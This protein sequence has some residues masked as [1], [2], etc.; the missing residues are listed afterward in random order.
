MPERGADAS[1]RNYSS[2]FGTKGRTG[3]FEKFEYERSYKDE[4]KAARLVDA[5]CA[6]AHP[7]PHRVTA[8]GSVE[9]STAQLIAQ[10]WAD[11]ISDLG[12][13]LVTEADIKGSA[14]T[15][16]PCA[17][18]EA[19]LEAEADI[20]DSEPTYAQRRRVEWEGRVTPKTTVFS[21][22]TPPLVPVLPACL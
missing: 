3:L 7:L 17:E 11:Q 14:N 21:V 20:K 22:R 16:Q 18:L 9:R 5:T 10:P 8:P 6:G 19:E 13:E 2:N 15:A 4:Y 1:K 12:T